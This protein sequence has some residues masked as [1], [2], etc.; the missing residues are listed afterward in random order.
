MTRNTTRHIQ[1]QHLQ[2]DSNMGQISIADRYLQKLKNKK[3]VFSSICHQNSIFSI[4]F[5]DLKKHSK[6]TNKNEN[7][8]ERIHENF[9]SYEIYSRI[10]NQNIEECLI[11]YIRQGNTQQNKIHLIIFPFRRKRPNRQGREKPHFQKIY[12][13]IYGIYTENLIHENIICQAW[14]PAHQERQ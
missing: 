13:H 1:L 5:T 14:N 6:W 11:A 2:S 3:A 9:K 7:L 10:P 12:N 4:V 8:K